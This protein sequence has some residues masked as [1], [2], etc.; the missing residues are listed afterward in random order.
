MLE[1]KHFKRKKHSLK[2]KNKK[3]KGGFSRNL[4]NN[5]NSRTQKEILHTI[6]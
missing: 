2:I 1:N 4:A 3:I 6:H 5:L